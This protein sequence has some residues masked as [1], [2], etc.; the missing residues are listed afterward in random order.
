M[1]KDDLKQIKEIID[2]S[3]E[4]HLGAVHEEISDLRTDMSEMHTDLNKL[5]A[6]VDHI[7]S[8]LGAFENSEVD[9]RKLLEVRVTHIEERISA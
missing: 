1:N 4:T 8:K 2:S 9:K 6:K 7:D 5:S 3:L